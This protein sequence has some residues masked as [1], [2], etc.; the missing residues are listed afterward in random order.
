MAEHAKALGLDTERLGRRIAFLNDRAEWHNRRETD[1]DQACAATARRDAGI[2]ALLLGEV[3][4]AKSSLR[5]AG[6]QFTELGLFA[7]YFLISIVDPEAD[8]SK[9]DKVDPLSRFDTS[10]DDQTAEAGRDGRPFEIASRNSPRQLLSLYQ[11]MRGGRRRSRSD[12]RIAAKA[13]E[14]LTSVSAAPLGTTGLPLKSY[15]SLFNTF[16]VNEPTQRDR[17][18]LFSVVTQ[19]EEMISA[20]RNDQFHWRMILK[21]AELVDL[22]LLALGLNAIEAGS[23]SRESLLSSLRHGDTG[24]SLPFLLAL[25]LRNATDGWQETL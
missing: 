13:E 17:D 14:R 5:D 25:D 19:R 22:D 15:L 24:G 21:P 23:N 9:R 11:A 8:L 12:A 6:R 10:D 3:E 7:G 2:L 20:A 18:I 16:G 4:V 1:I